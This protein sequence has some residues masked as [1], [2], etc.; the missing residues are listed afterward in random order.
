MGRSENLAIVTLEKRET[1]LGTSSRVLGLIPRRVDSIFSGS[2]VKLNL[3][4]KNR[5]FLKFTLKVSHTKQPAKNG[6]RAVYYACCFYDSIWA[7]QS[8]ADVVRLQSDGVGR[9]LV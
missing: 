5:L 7:F 1:A 4:V 2:G 8:F 3:K 6:H 9:A